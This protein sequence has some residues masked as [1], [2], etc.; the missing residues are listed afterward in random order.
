MIKI[1]HAKTRL[2]RIPG[3]PL[4]AMPKGMAIPTHDFVTLEL[5]TDQGIEGIGISSCGDALGGVLKVAVE[6]MAELIK[7]MDALRPEAIAAKLRAAASG[8]GPG[9][10][11]TTAL[12]AIDIA[13]WDIRGKAANQSVCNLAGGHRERVPTYASG[14]LARNFPAEHNAKV[15]ADLKAQGWKQMKTQMG[16]MGYSNAEEV[17]RMRAIREAIGDDTDLMCDINQN[18]SV[19]QAIDMGRRVAEINLFWLE[20][21]VAHDDYPGMGRVNAET[22]MPIAAGEYVYGGVP[23]RHL[24]E[25]RSIDIVMIDIF[26]A[27]GVTGWMKIAAMAE[28]FNLPVVSHVA[29][30]LQVHLVAACP[31]GLTVEY[32]PW[33]VELF[34]EVPVMEQGEIAVPKKP[35]FGLK[36]DQKAL[37]RYSVG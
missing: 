8:A 26:R 28:A 36:F 7:G 31:N 35:G 13:I 21:P 9:G 20:D 3:Q 33:S 10:I 19:H 29:P 32:M 25:A 4:A 15:A 17:R 22:T 14:A 1:T 30:E 34:E 11:F 37:Q 16:G 6:K 18:W 12:A 2:V 5:G 27:G 24:I 23:F